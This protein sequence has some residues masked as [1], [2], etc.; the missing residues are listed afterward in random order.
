MATLSNV[1]PSVVGNP[2]AVQV[3]IGGIQQNVTQVNAGAQNGTV[4]VSFVVSQSFNGAAVP[5]LVAV[6]GVISDPVSI[7]VK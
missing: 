7:I 5:V 3:A 6:K 4:T 2:S 1:D